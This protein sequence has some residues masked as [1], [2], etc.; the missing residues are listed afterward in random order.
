MNIKEIAFN[1]IIADEGFKSFIYEDTNGIPTIGHGITWIT[2][3][4]SKQIVRNRIDDISN[5][6]ND[7]LKDMD[8]SLDEFRK[9]I[10]I[11]M[12]YQ[13][14][15]NGLLSF[16]QMFAALKDMDYDRAADAMLDSLWHNQTKARCERE[17]AKMRNGC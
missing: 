2:E 8:I 11:N 4:E 9:T 13:L 15:K 14:G 1:Q 3:E 10:L 6:I 17:A 16:K 5:F 12:C 7:T